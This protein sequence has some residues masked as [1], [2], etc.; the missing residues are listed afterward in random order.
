[1]E[2][3]RIELE[4]FR[5]RSATG[6]PITIPQTTTQIAI[7]LLPTTAL[8]RPRARHPDVEP[9]TGEDLRNYRPF[10]VNLRTKFTIDGACLPDEEERVLY[11][12]SRLRGKASQRMLPWLLAK[13]DRGQPLRTNDFYEALDKAFGDPDAKTKALVRVNTMKQGSKDFREFLGE[14]DEALSDAGGLL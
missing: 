5:T 13:Q 11:A 3:L 12:F 14:F 9:F 7:L 8:S 6:R 2:L 4:G 10:R 1:M